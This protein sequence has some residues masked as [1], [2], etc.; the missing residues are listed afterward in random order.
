M[1]FK[2][3]YTT[4]PRI[5]SHVCGIHYE[6]STCYSYTK[7]FGLPRSLDTGKDVADR[8]QTRVRRDGDEHTIQKWTFCTQ[9]GRRIC[10]CVLFEPTDGP[11]F[12]NSF[13]GHSLSGEDSIEGVLL[14]Q[15]AWKLGGGGG[16]LAGPFFSECIGNSA[17]NGDGFKS[18]KLISSY[19][20]IALTVWLR[21]E[22]R[23]G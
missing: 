19:A 22:T 23:G 18:E 7:S 10:K 4:K 12:V 15:Y 1:T 21:V 6:I 20:I 8:V 13:T 11:L 17:H 14:F 16:P 9:V 5:E 3:R 2:V